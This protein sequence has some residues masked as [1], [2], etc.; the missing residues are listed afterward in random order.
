MKKA[1]TFFDAKES[2]DQIY[3]LIK[4]KE[5]TPV[6][7]VSKL[8]SVG[9]KHGFSVYSL[10]IILKAKYKIRTRQ[11]DSLNTEGWIHDPG[12]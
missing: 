12:Q 10:I 4:F 11:S 9:K 7:D 1:N 8:F 3:R 2:I 5:K 6:Q